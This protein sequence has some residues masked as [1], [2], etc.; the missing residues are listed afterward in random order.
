MPPKKRR[1]QH[2]KQ[3]NLNKAAMDLKRQREERF[4]NRAALQERLQKAE[5]EKKRQE[6]L[7]N[8][9]SSTITTPRPDSPR[10]A[11]KRKKPSTPTVSTEN[12]NSG[13]SNS[14]ANVPQTPTVSNAPI[15]FQVLRVPAMQSN[16][17]L[18]N[19]VYKTFLDKMYYDFDDFDKKLLKQSKNG[20]ENLAQMAM[21]EHEDQMLVT[22]AVSGITPKK[23]Q[24]KFMNDVAKRIPTGDPNCPPLVR[25]AKRIWRRIQEDS[26][27]LA[28]EEDGSVSDNE[29]T[30]TATTTTTTSGSNS[31]SSNSNSSSRFHVPSSQMSNMDGG[32]SSGSRSS[33]KKSTSKS[34]SNATTR[35]WGS[36]DGMALMAKYMFDCPPCKWVPPPPGMVWGV[37]SKCGAGYNFSTGEKRYD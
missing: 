7:E 15:E 23:L 10:P 11:E 30:T 32:S 20:R 24:R 14:I 3:K 1:K 33:K 27:N 19:E 4:A 26:V 2:F 35:K 8:C 18:V 13:S 5:E 16:S 9:S 21:D 31:S 28:L 34:T 6:L 12:A 17:R 29:T 22:S 36:K 25:Q 37:C